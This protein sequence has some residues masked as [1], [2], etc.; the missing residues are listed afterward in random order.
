MNNMKSTPSKQVAFTKEEMR[1][2]VLSE[3]ESSFP[4]LKESLGEKKFKKRMEK[5]ARLLTK[6]LPKKAQVTEKPRA[7]KKEKN[8]ATT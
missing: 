3:M 7:K 8:P 5:A 2:A 4:Q 1:G 6:G